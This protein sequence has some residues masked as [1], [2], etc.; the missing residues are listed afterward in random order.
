MNM[1]VDDRV[2]VPPSDVYMVMSTFVLPVGC[3]CLHRVTCFYACRFMTPEDLNICLYVCRFM[4]PEDL[5]IC[6]YVRE[7]Q[8]VEDRSPKDAKDFLPSTCGLFKLAHRPRFKHGLV[9]VRQVFRPE[10]VGA[11]R[12]FSHKRAGGFA[13]G[14]CPPIYRFCG[15]HT[16]G[17][18]RPAE[19]SGSTSVEAG[20]PAGVLRE[21]PDW[22]RGLTGGGT[23]WRSPLLA[24]G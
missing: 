7:G 1:G 3:L 13:M 2:F 19:A 17:G 6:L 10:G 20:R 18:T 5:N 23:C 24:R 8:N 4:T 12:F 21:E 22:R 9:S 16:G 11:L 14:V 15:G